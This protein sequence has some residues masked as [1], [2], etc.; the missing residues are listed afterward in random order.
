MT[1]QHAP[2]SYETG[3]AKERI[4]LAEEIDELGHVN[5]AVYV[6]WLQ[7]IA[8]QHWMA[9]ASPQMVERFVW[10]CRRHEIDYRTPL[11]AGERVCVTTWVGDYQGAKFDR[12]VDIRKA[13]ADAWSVRAKTT[14]VMLDRASGKPKRILGEVAELFGTPA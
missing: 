13:G 2:R 10:V 11:F 4:V 8:V 12:H 7:D 6:R 14:W 5:N 1:P 3:F 9:A